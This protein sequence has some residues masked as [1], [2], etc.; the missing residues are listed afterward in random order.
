MTCR[1]CV[2][3]RELEAEG[4]PDLAWS[5]HMNCKGNCDRDHGDPDDGRPE[6]G[7]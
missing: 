3:A 1:N 2:T 4:K 7:P 5:F 6:N